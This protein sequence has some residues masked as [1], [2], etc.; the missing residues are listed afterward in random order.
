MP[1]L[2]EVQLLAD[3]RRQDYDRYLTLLFLKPKDRFRLALL[4]AFNQEIG[5]IAERVTE[6]LIGEMRLTWWRD[7]LSAESRPKHPLAEALI[8]Q[9]AKE[10]LPRDP[11]LAMIE[12]RR[13]ELDKEP[14]ADLAEMARHARATAGLLNETA[15][16]VLGASDSDAAE[17]LGTAWGLI[18]QLRS[19]PFHAAAGRVRLPQDLLSQAGL[20]PS[21]IAGGRA[22]VEALASVGKQ[23]AAQAVSHLEAAGRATP[24]MASGREPWLLLGTLARHHLERLEKAE[25][26]LFDPRLAH[27]AGKQSFLLLKA[28][29]TKRW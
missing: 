7:T 16:S 2:A 17:E 5:Q 14:F 28:R 15:A 24:R 27:S 9:I 3:L 19:V 23:I 11:L 26:H 12:P 4:L 25:W 18:G 22:P 6:P 20:Q 8:A 13:R 29:L 10:Q 1:G 21:Q